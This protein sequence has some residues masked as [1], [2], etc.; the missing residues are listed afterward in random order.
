MARRVRQDCP[1]SPVLFNILMADVEEEMGKVRWERIKLG[2]G[3]VYSLAYADDMMLLAEGEN[4][5]R[6]M[7]EWLERYLVS[8]NLELDTEKSK[9]MRFRK[10]GERMGKREWRWEGRVIE[11]VKE[12]NI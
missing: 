11:E 4:E 7:M 12:T 2:E 1:L 8:K 5:M 10:G 9:I 3:R 6:S